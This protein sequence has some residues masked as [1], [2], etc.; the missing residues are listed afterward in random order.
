MSIFASVLNSFEMNKKQRKK[1]KLRREYSKQYAGTVN[2]HLITHLK[3]CNYFVINIPLDGDAPKQYIKAYFYYKNC[4][5][6]KKYNSWDGYYAKFGGK[7]YPHESI[8]EFGINKV[9]EALGLKMNET[10]LVNAN[11]QIR[12][13]SKDFIERGKKKLIHGVEILH[14][15]FEDKDFI[16]EINKDRKSRRELLTF[17]V[18]ENA[19]RHVHPRQSEELLTE[20]VKLITFD[21]IVGNND[22]HF[23]NWGVIGDVI[24]A[25]D[26]SVEFAPIYDTARGLLWN[27]MESQVKQI[28]RQYK[29]GSFDQMN[30][31]LVKSKP[32]FSFE[33]NPKSNHFEFIEHLAQRS[34]T[35]K[36]VITTLIG[37]EVEN[38]VLLKLK[39]T[40]FRYFSEERNYLIAEILKL[41]F[42]KLR[43]ITGCSTY[44]NE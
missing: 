27:K 36:K 15:Y 5:R 39:D 22:R 30:A 11:N 4:P 1:S 3:N 23:Y 8:T 24:N 42:Q 7:S 28:Y 17:D 21:A 38:C 41:R 19:I 13:L 29:N 20:L 35:Y 10:R 40:I 6:K 14:E 32:R 26:R 33:G 31:F 43:K 44:L 37:T 12:F 2:T 25:S 16:D 34:T 9:G 18:V